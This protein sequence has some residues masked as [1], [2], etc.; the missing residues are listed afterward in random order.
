M[1]FKPLHDRVVVKPLEL[2]TKTAGGLIEHRNIREQRRQ[3]IGR[4]RKAI[5]D[6]LAI[7]GHKIDGRPALEGF[8]LGGEKS[9]RSISEYSVLA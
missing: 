6:Q 5:G 7:A 2:D 3:P 9:A 1:K 8:A 4:R